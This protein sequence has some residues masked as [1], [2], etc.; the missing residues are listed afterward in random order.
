MDK[1]PVYKKNVAIIGGGTVSHVKSHLALS[2][3]AYGSTA[4]RL[5]EICAEH[6][7]KLDI[8][9]Y[10]TRMANSGRG[11]LETNED[12]A[13]LVE[14]LKQD[15][16]TKIIFFNPAMTDFNGIVYLSDPYK[17]RG[18]T[19]WPTPSGKYADRLKTRDLSDRTDM[20]LFKNRRSWFTRKKPFNYG[21]ITKRYK[22]GSS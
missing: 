22:E 5:K 19:K 11:D 2:A 8:D 18:E 9:L 4:R 3:P 14:E 21:G 10:L 13:K 6:S 20:G 1:T 15:V 7:D 12:I 16:Q 17:D